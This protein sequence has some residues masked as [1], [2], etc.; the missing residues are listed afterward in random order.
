M[1]IKRFKLLSSSSPNQWKAVQILC[2]IYRTNLVCY[3]T[4]PIFYSTNPVYYYASPICYSTKPVCYSGNPEPVW[5]N[6]LQCHFAFPCGLK[7][8]WQTI[9]FERS[10]AMTFPTRTSC[11]TFT[12]CHGCRKGIATCPFMRSNDITANHETSREM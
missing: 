12:T 1:R 3:S 7:R 9:A 2:P 8:V 11:N 5:C 10:V 6:L 4:S